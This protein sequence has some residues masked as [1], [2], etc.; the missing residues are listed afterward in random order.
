MGKEKIVAIAV[1]LSLLTALT[2]EVSV[3]E[4]RAAERTVLASM[5]YQYTGT[6]D[7]EMVNGATTTDLNKSKYGSKKN[8]YSFTKGSARIYASIDGKNLRKMEWSSESKAVAKVYNMGGTMEASPIMAAG[9]K[10]VSNKWTKGTKPYFEIRLSTKG[11]SAIYFSA[12]VAASKKGPRDYALTYAVGDSN[13]FQAVLGSATKL[14]LTDNK[15]FARISG[16]LPSAADNQSLV[17]IRIEVSSMQIVST[18]DAGVYLYSNPSSGEAAINH[19]MISG[20]KVSSSSTTGNVNNKTTTTA[21][22]Q[23]AASG[24]V[25]TKK[26]KKISLNKKKLTLKKGKTYKLKVSYKPNT[27]SIKEAAGK[28]IKW[29]SSNKKVITVTKTG[30]IKAKKVGKATITVTYSKKIKAICKVKVR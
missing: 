28:K 27:K 18:K 5:D 13:S 20:S 14:S 15:K 11:Y 23:S 21:S 9:S 10:D 17:K 1:I 26:L 7:V 25:K 29:K 22:Q 24:S 12:Y 30:K 16:T 4:V 19:V 2:G 8:G 6:S 3:S